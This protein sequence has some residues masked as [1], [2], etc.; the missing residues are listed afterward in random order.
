MHCFNFSFL[1]NIF[2]KSKG[3]QEEKKIQTPAMYAHRGSPFTILIVI[4]TIQNDPYMKHTVDNMQELGN[5]FTYRY[6]HLYLN[7][8]ADATVGN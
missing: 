2:V 4:K 3:W 6:M 8:H 7:I 5:F 1:F